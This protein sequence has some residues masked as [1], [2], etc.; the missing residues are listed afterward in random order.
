MFKA[1]IHK[2]VSHYK[3]ANKNLIPR[4]NVLDMVKIPMSDY[5]FMKYS[6][7][8]S[9]EIDMIKIKEETKKES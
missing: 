3:T 1:R 4:K 6:V 5:Q 9:A 7:V 2:L 8:R